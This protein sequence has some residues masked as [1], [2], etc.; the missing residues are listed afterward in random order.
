MKTA[1]ASPKTTGNHW[2]LLALSPLGP[3]PY[4]A[5]HVAIPRVQGSQLVHYPISAFSLVARGHSLHLA[6][7]LALRD[8]LLSKGKESHSSSEDLGRNG[9]HW[10]CGVSHLSLSHQSPC[11]EDK[12]KNGKETCE[13]HGTWFRLQP[14]RLSQIYLM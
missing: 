12:K 2:K 14:Y 1:F 8:F 11:E 9:P 6:H 3:S 5:Q 4:T 7:W 13:R 10:K